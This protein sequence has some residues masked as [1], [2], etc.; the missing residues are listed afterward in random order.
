MWLIEGVAEYIAGATQPALPR[1][2]P[3][4]IAVRPLRDGAGEP[5]VAAFY[6]LG[7]SAIACL[8]AKFGEPRAMEFVRLRLRL[9]Y[10]L[11]IAA[12]SVFGRSFD[13]V[14]RDCGKWI[15]AG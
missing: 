12:R 6:A 9:G 15:G 13:T 2:R 11:D 1:R 8:A 7:H 10:S 3:A 5:E 4:S 14:D